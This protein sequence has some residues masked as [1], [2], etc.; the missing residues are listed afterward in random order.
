MV[1]AIATR[2]VATAMTPTLLGND[3]RGFYAAIGV[4]LPRSEGDNVSVR[5]FVSPD[6]HR[7]GDRNPSCSVNLVHGAWKC[8]G[9]GAEGGAFD[10]ADQLGIDRRPAIELLRRYGI[11][12]RDP[13]KTTPPPKAR[14]GTPKT[15]RAP[16]SHPPR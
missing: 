16:E 14:R 10:A 11:S 7:R 12:K 15:N 1:R 13:A 9:C 6:Q 2:P 3:V 5:C 4:Q 8:H